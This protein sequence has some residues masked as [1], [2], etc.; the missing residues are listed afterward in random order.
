M[1]FSKIL[2]SPAGTR[3]S[4]TM[5]VMLRNHK[6][7]MREPQTDRPWM[8]WFCPDSFPRLLWASGLKLCYTSYWSCILR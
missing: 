6:Q 2:A 1:P 3:G 7:G 4:N 8:A 5:S